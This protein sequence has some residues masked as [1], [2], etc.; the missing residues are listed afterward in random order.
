[1]MACLQTS[2]GA[3]HLHLQPRLLQPPRLFGGE[4]KKMSSAQNFCRTVDIKIII[5]ITKKHSIRK[6]MVVNINLIINIMNIITDIIINNMNIITD[7]I[8]N[9]ITI[10]TDIIINIIHFFSETCRTVGGELS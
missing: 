3:K 10:I 1:M 8:L 9:I 7:I 2:L 6:L 4:S 5:D